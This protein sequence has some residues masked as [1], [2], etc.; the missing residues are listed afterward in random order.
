[1]H[2]WAMRIR[3][4]WPAAICGI[5]SAGAAIGVSECVAA[6]TGVWTAPVVAVGG[7]VID[8]VPSALKDFAIRTFGTHDK[9]ALVI[10][11]L[12][13][14]T[15]FAAVVGLAAVRRPGLGDLGVV[16][17]GIVGV[18]AA[19]TRP[20][21]G[22]LAALPTLLGVCVAIPV[23]R[24]LIRSVPRQGD[25]G[26][27]FFPRQGDAG[28]AVAGGAVARRGDAP[29]ELEREDAA[30]RA[31][32][33]RRR[34]FGLVASTAAVAVAAGLGGRWLASL[35]DVARERESVSLPQP[36]SPA[37]PLE[38]DVALDVS[39]LTPFVTPDEDFYRIDT[40][41]VVPQVSTRGWHLRVHGR[42]ATPLT[43]TWE[44][45]LARPMIERYTTLTCVSNEVGGDLI[46]TA[47]WRGVPV[48]DLLAEA[49]PQPGADQVVGRSADGFTAGTP[50]AVLLDGRDAMLAVAMNGS[51]LPAEHGFP[52]R[53]VVPG[54]YGYVSATKW[55]VELEV[56]SFDAF[57]AYWVPRGW[58]NHAPIKTGSR[59]DTPRDGRTIR[60]GQVNIAGV[61]WAQHRGV[62]AVEVQ[63]DDGPWQRAR[64]ASV[65]STDTWRQWVMPWQ[66]GSGR[67]RITVRA[68]DSAGVTQTAERQD[69]APDGATG[70]H[71]VVVTVK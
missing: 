51:P 46:G 69:P 34:L 13:L 66:A 21:A 52:V 71:T 19:V 25:A 26:G 42:V 22:A 63:V 65:P 1:M 44:Q 24:L 12:V 18:A 15:V 4:E 27:A 31:T 61:A 53:M 14:L 41:I 3:Q 45:L 38:R 50:T 23:L 28:G 40:A 58:A 56:T 49:G 29:A 59:I 54:L 17:F 7:A 6:L 39:G 70:L 68:V 8:S 16:V 60:A 11:T 43:I 35:R 36:V 55:L 62:D 67:H 48:R 37:G 2:S 10:G 64:L 33:G 47:L 9:T 20:S 30:E 57:D 5:V 32:L